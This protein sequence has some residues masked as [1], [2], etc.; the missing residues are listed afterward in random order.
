MTVNKINGNDYYVSDDSEADALASKR[1]RVY[2]GMG[3]RG[4]CWFES[5]FSAYGWKYMV[6]IPEDK[7]IPWTQETVPLY[8]AKQY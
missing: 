3:S 8:G 4:R 1:L 5:G 6:E 2:I 7:Y